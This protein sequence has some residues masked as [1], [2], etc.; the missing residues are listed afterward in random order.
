MSEPEAPIAVDEYFDEPDEEVCI[1]CG[2]E[3]PRG[4]YASFH[5]PECAYLDEFDA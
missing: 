4:G 2:V 1:Q 5:C 3:A